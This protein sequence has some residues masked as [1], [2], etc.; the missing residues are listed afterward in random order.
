[1]PAEVGEENRFSLGRGQ[2]VDGSPA[3][4][5]QCSGVTRDLDLGRW[6]RLGGLGITVLMAVSL[7]GTRDVDSS[8]VRPGYKPRSEA[9][10]RRVEALGL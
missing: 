5:G 2:L 6:G 3:R 7:V 9:A 4:L 8:A 10:L 1:V